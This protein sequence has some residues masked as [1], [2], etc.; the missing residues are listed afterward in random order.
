MVQHQDG[1]FFPAQVL[2][3]P[4]YGENG[5]LLGF[6]GVSVDITERKE[7]ETALRQ[8]ANMLEN[9]YDAIFMWELGGKVVYW[10]RGAERLYGYSKAE[11]LEQSSHTL[12]QTMHPRDIQVFEATLHRERE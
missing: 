7:A 3:S 8:Q 12:L 1:T 6:V 2:N 5:A 11:A 9:T 4:I 10:N